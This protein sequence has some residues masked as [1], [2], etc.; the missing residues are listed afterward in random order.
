MLLKMIH[1]TF[2]LICARAIITALVKLAYSSEEDKQFFK[3]S[4]KYLWFFI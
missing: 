1:W 3:I 4:I 2:I